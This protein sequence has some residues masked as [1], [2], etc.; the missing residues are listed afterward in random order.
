MWKSEAQALK[1]PCRDL[2]DSHM[3]C[4]TKKYFETFL[5]LNKINVCFLMGG[6]QK[7]VQNY[8]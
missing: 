5:V 8:Y 2:C 6:F 1:P 4:K 3:Q 7:Q